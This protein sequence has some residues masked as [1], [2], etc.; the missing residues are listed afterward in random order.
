[1]G[2]LGIEP[3]YFLD[4]MSQDE[5][6][7]I[8]DAKNT[9][10]DADI[11]IKHEMIKV[12]WEQVRTLCYYT[13]IA[14]NGTKQFQKPEDLFMFKWEKGNGEKQNGRRL[15]KDEFYERAKKILNG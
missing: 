6:M 2:I 5:T 14:F 8:M 1:M 12:S 7:A 9:V 15:T 13:Y 3:R 11:K 10:N 4:E